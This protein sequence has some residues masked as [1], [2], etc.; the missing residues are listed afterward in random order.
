M[1]EIKN[2]IQ[3]KAVTL[4]QDNNVLLSWATGTGKSLAAIKIATKITDLKWYI[5]CK[6]TTHIENWINEFKKHKIDYSNFEIFCYDSLH[7]YSDTKA[8]IILDEVHCITELRVSLLKKIHF[9]K[10]IALSATV[11]DE[12]KEILQ[13]LVSFKEYHISLSEAINTGI[14][15]V[16]K[17]YI[18]DIFLN[19]SEPTET[20]ILKKG[21][22][23]KRQIVTCNF[24]ERYKVFKEYK[25][26]E[27][28]IKCTQK[29]RYDLLV[30]E[31]EYYKLQHFK[32]KKQ[33]TEFNWL[34]A[35]L[36][37]KKFLSE[38]KTNAAR[39]ILKQ[40][41][42]KRLICFTG[43]IEQCNELGEKYAIHSKSDIDSNSLIDQFNKQKINKLFAVKMLREGINLEKI[44]SSIIIQLDNQ[45]LSFIQM[46][47]R[48]IRGLL[49]ECYILVV[50]NTQDEVYLN[51]A[52]TGFDNKYLY[53][54]D[55]QNFF[56]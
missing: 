51:T 23:D 12:K 13:T 2:L 14:V 33:W 48:C 52:L 43:S 11:P 31:I 45:L 21:L 7:K 15:P 25:D 8:N 27:L 5:V 35:G 36:K 38:I 41:D 26:V 22:K 1:S 10:M 42:K 39:E 53:K 17:I 54:F 30:S 9:S 16:P 28:H 18:V 6:E 47:G 44:D 34:Q 40:L 37:R 19:N 56:K 55:K 4:A 3:N 24:K 46:L 49:P 32:L 20:H 29:E 50:R